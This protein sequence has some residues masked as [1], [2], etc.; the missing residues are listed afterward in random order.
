M[1]L[2]VE[3]YNLGFTS[4]AL[5]VV[6]M[7]ALAKLFLD[8]GSWDL[9]GKKALADNI[10]KQMRDASAR[11][12]L[13]EFRARLSN[14]TPVQLELFRDPNSEPR[15]RMALLAV[16]KRYR[17]VADFSEQA[18]L[19]K[20]DAFDFELRPSD[21]SYFVESREDLHPELLK[22]SE[23]SR[24]K[25][26]QVTLRMLKEGEILSSTRPIQITP[27]FLSESVV[28]VIRDDDPALLRP[29]LVPGL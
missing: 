26:R 19:P 8:T 6:H 24:N 7:A 15:R 9:A 13:R 17:F 2:T 10:F 18:L 5:G 14:L 11:R 12:L 25:I 16:F 28:D 27:P 1:A 4:T 20:V 29:F 23:T 21:Y 3:K 22:V